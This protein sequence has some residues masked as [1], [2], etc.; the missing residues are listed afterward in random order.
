MQLTKLVLST[1]KLHNFNIKKVKLMSIQKY[2]Y[3]FEK[4]TSEVLLKWENIPPAIVS[5]CM[6]RTNAMASRI[7]PLAPGMRLVGQARTVASMVGDNSA[8]HAAIGMLDVGEVLVIDAKAHCDTAVWGGVMT[9]AALKKKIGGVVI[10][11]AVRDASE[12][13]ALGFP[14]FCAGIVPTGPSKGF[15]GVI[16]DV[17]SCGGCSVMPGDLILGDDDGISVVPLMRQQELLN[18]SIRQME[19]EDNMSDNIEK[20][21]LPFESFHQK[22]DYL[23]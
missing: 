14:T 8:S 19:L 11:G 16:D 15:G 22:V 6:N 7:A 13:R 9:K 2:N 1:V 3:N 12:I 21:I 10:D 17:I 20:G 23:D 4:L 5:D 18:A